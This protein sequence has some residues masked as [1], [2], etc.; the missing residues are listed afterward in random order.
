MKRISIGLEILNHKDLIVNY[1]LNGEISSF[2]YS[3]LRKEY[4]GLHESKEIKDFCF[5][6]IIFKDAKY[7]SDGIH[8]T[9]NSRA[10]LLSLVLMM[11]IN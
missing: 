2:I 8:L 11:L 5:S 4:P 1:S 9:N 3:I 6:N 7:E 10:W